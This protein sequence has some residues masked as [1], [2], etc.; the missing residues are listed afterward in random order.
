M[1]KDEL[2]QKIKSI[3]VN[4]FEVEEEKVL[5]DAN[6]TFDDIEGNKLLSHFFFLIAE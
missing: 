3:M 2:Y 4:E 1:T 5:P 6:N